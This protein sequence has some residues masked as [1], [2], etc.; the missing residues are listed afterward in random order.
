[1]PNPPYLTGFSDGL[2]FHTSETACVAAP[3]TLHNGRGRLKLCF[4]TA[5]CI[6]ERLPA[7]FQFST[8]NAPLR[9]ET[10]ICVP[11]TARIRP[12]I[13]VTTFMAFLPSSRVICGPKM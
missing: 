7:A 5:L 4:Q 12:I 10:S 1:M 3:H 8:G 11:M 13:R 2:S 6:F 9:P